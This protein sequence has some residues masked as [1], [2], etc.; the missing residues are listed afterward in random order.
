MVVYEKAIKI[1][2]RAWAH[3]ARPARPA[4]PAKGIH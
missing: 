3:A 2:P 4:N 1:A